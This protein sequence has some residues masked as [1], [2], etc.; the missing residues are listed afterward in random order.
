MSRLPPKELSSSSNDL[1]VVTRETYPNAKS[2][3]RRLAIAPLSCDLKGSSSITKTEHAINSSP[4]ASD[5]RTRRTKV[6]YSAN[7]RSRSLNRVT[8]NQLIER[9]AG[10]LAEEKRRLYYFEDRSRYLLVISSNND[11]LKT[12]MAAEKA[13]VGE[14]SSSSASLLEK[15]T[16]GGVVSWDGCAVDR[17]KAANFL[18]IWVVTLFASP[19][20]NLNCAQS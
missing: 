13:Q 19:R 10:A 9:P 4:G 5:A 8:K 12:T 1:R 17:R 18:Y 16:A 14:G 15:A 6:R 11:T 2:K 3:W 7:T 20:S